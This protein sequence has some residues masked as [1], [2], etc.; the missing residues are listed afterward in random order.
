MFL[1]RSLTATH[2][3]FFQ[4][5]KRAVQYAVIYVGLSTSNLFREQKT[6]NIAI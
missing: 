4:T 1:I 2:N 6:T 5:A 3:S